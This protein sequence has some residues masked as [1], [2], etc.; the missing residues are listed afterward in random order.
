MSAYTN[1]RASKLKLKG[2]A[3]A[4]ARYVLSL[5]GR[6]TVCVSR[7][8][9]DW[10]IDWSGDYWLSD[11]SSYRLIDWLIDWLWDWSIDWLIDWLICGG[12]RLIHSQRSCSVDSNVYDCSSSSSSI[13]KKRKR[14]SVA[15]SADKDAALVSWTIVH[16]QD[17][18]LC[19]LLSLT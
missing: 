8:S 11:W 15:T 13:D 3:S 9:I 12:Q 2:T 18:F 6:L 17:F 14:K 5:P 16:R 7:R 19:H 10:L 4:K 1:V